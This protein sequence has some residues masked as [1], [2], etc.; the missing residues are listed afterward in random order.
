MARDRDG[1]LW[2]GTETGLS[3]FDGTHFRNFYMSDGLPDNEI[4]K[5]FVDSRNRVWIVPFKNSICYYLNGMIHNQQN[6]PLLGRLKIGSEVISVNEDVHG[7]LIIAESKAID[8]VHPGG[9][10][11]IIDR[12]EGWPFMVV[13]AGLDEKGEC[14]FFISS[15]SPGAQVAV[16]RH[17]V[18]VRTG[19]LEGEGEN[20]YTSTYLG[21]ELLIYEDKD[22]L[23]FLQAKEPGRVRIPSPKGFLHISRI[24]DSS[25]TL[26][27]YSSTYLY[28][29]RQHRI[30]DS[31]LPG[32][33]VN[34]ALEDAE[35]GLWFSTL[36]SGVH[37]L[38][39][40][41]VERYTFRE[42][43]TVFPVF[44][45]QRI[46]NTLYAGTDR[47]YLW[48]RQEGE[49]TFRSM[50]VDDKFSRGRITAIEDL[51]NNS[52]LAGTD[53]GVF[54]FDAPRGQSRRLWHRGAVKAIRKTGDSMLIEFS[55][56]NVRRLRLPGGTLL[57]TVFPGR[58][59][60][61][62][63]RG[64]R[65][66]VGTLNG[67]YAVSLS[68][69]TQPEELLEGRI[70]AITA[71]PDSGIWVATYGEGLVLLRKGRPVSRFTV[72]DGLTSNICR[73]LYAVGGSVWVGTDKGLNRVAPR[74]GGYI[75]TPFTG[76]E[77]L[78]VDVINTVYVDGQ[79]VYAGTPDGMLV[80]QEDRIV[81]SK[82]CRLRLT[83]IH[84]SGGSWPLDTANF[85]LPYR[86]NDLQIEYVGISYRNS[87]PID[88][89]YRLLGIDDRWATTDQTFLHY[90]SLPPGR[91]ELQVLAIDPSGAIS[92]TL[93]LP[94]A[95]DKPWW[96]LTWVRIGLVLL[97]A[98]LVWLIF[99]YRVRT[100]RRKEAEKTA[101]AARMA[102][103]EQMA[104]RSRMNPHFIFNSLNSIQ[105][106]VMEKDIRGA[107][108]YITH[109]SRLIRQTLDISARSQLTLQEE[110][111]YLSTYLE[112]EKRRFEE[113]FDY[114]IF[115]AADVDK[116]MQMLPTMILQPYVENA[117]LHGIAHRQDKQGKIMVLFRSDGHFLICMIEDNGVGRERAAQYKRQVPG[118]YP[119]R[120]MELTAR[121][122]DILNSTMKEPI[123][124]EIE[125]I[126]AVG[127]LGEG[128]RVIVRFPL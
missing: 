93:R 1:F 62:W 79:R 96:E 117:I 7:D 56:S 15:H 35:G 106:F 81:R 5:V 46:G 111:D 94:F 27:S 89:R 21:P 104:L 18:L 17:D 74:D 58:S 60:C 37:R 113:A 20:N 115:V 54:R 43:N 29:V 122:I 49:K 126:T 80:F 59:T 30:V 45:I 109:F 2:F 36:G 14:K 48:S 47:F 82:D 50:K 118:Q 97:I 44:T 34:G 32:Q 4:I 3:R 57:D 125:D 42:G 92:G 127:G 19:D 70:S 41:D 68:R 78:G 108:E 22:S 31:F 25:V 76:A 124:A 73:C 110:I 33:M 105:L 119:S 51:G 77:G 86:N 13:Q 91:Y 90:P 28:N 85:I 11:T 66:F 24:D 75:I 23:T 100:I 8:V 98:G 65:C 38:A 53:A 64:D 114:D 6:D 101:T 69:R 9:K 10:I 72:A 40:R 84:I 63:V 39:N 95:I 121:R 52:I 102:E 12:F 123:S 88:Y 116:R 120:G 71:A 55:G 67:L 61:G 16:I 112:L 26:N 103:L 99:S 87:G 83:G 128:T 107:N